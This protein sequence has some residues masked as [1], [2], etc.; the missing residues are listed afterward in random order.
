M[1]R[2]LLALAAT[3]TLSAC[4]DSPAAPGEREPTPPDP[5][6]GTD[7]SVAAQSNKC[8]R[9]CLVRLSIEPGTYAMS[10][11]EH[12]ELVGT[13][14][15]GPFRWSKA[16]GLVR[17]YTTGEWLALTSWHRQVAGNRMPKAVIWDSGG[18]RVLE[19]PNMTYAEAR[20][21]ND[22]GRVVGTY[23]RQGDAAS[24]AYRWSPWSGTT[25]LPSL[26]A[27]SNAAN[28]INHANDAV[29]YS[30][31]GP[32]VRRAVLWSMAGGIR[33]LGMLPGHAGSEAV[34]IS[35]KGHVAVSS[36]PAG[37]SSVGAPRPR[38]ALWTEAGGLQPLGTLGGEISIPAD[39]NSWGE[40]VGSSTTA[41]GHSHAFVWYGPT[42]MVRLDEGGAGRSKALAIN[43]WGDIIGTLNDGELVAWVWENNL[44]RWQ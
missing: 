17:Q 6:T 32:E 10:L 14:Y 11:N 25:V 36:W 38:A 34:A 40:V 29:G 30:T 18:T 5:P 2:V 4:L 24:V 31:V 22:W 33:E 35:N 26:S 8:P 12:A 7:P 41:D 21:I 37:L 13:G 28:D 39:V 9:R 3:L 42:G 20:S 19:L 27:H 15:E 44:W 16:T 1:K 43:S 23:H